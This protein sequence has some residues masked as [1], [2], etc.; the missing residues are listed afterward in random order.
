MKPEERLLTPDEK[1]RRKAVLD[2]DEVRCP[3][4]VD[5]VQ[6]RMLAGYRFVK[7]SSPA[8][9]E[10]IKDKRVRLRD[11]KHGPRTMTLSS[12]AH[13][14]I[15]AIR[16]NSDDCPHRVTN[17]PSTTSPFICAGGFIGGRITGGIFR[18]SR[19]CCR[20]RR[21]R[22]CR[23]SGR[24]P[25][26]RRGLRQFAGITCWTGCGRRAGSAYQRSSRGTVLVVARGH[27]FHAGHS[28]G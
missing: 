26:T 24:G 21:S 28:K 17:C 5:R 7:T 1:A 27:R 20:A 14:V 12:A 19:A 3:H 8:R 9:G 25:R 10:L 16:R 22:A 23:K 13:S 4:A 18:F 2:R 11:F 15:D 6:P